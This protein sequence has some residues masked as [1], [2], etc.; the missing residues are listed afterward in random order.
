MT[1]DAATSLV[2]DLRN[3]EF[4]YAR[5]WI[6]RLIQR[7]SR[8]PVPSWLFYVAVISAIAL[9]NNAVFWVDGSLAA[10]SINSQRVADSGYIVFFVALYHHLSLVA[11]RSFQVYR[12]VLK[13]PDPD[14]R[15]LEYRLTTLPRRLGWLAI[16]LGIGLGIVVVQSDPG[17]FGLD[18]A[19]TLLPVIYQHAAM[20]F[21]L[22]SMI[23]L[24]LQ[25]IRQLRLVNDLHRQA[26][27]INL[28]RLAPVHA[29][30]SLTARAGIGLVAFIAFNGLVEG[31]NVTGS[32]LFAL[33]VMGIL[34]ILVFIAP[35][36]GMRNRLKD[37][38]ARLLSETNE[39]IQV[40]IGRIQNRVNSNEYENISGLNIAMSAL[41]VQRD[42]VKGISTWP[43]EPS[44]L[45]G[46]ASTL[47]LPIFLWLVTRLLER[48][49]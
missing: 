41:V 13:S 38:K 30:A 33:I 22:S 27:Q 42:L 4:P 40:T 5:S 45:S 6:D 1:Q 7:I 36:L 28:F 2:T 47:L 26:S 24:I 39:A 43:W 16:V 32:N 46:F 44:T 11:R 18:A 48:L 37:E 19:M 35:L 14:L 29:L 21:V 25:T 49:I 31:L 15:I 17:P 20:I 34:A 23:T 12:P 10:G 8:I 3:S 9:L